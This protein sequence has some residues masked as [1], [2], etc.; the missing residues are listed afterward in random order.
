[1]ETITLTFGTKGCVN[2]SVSKVQNNYEEHNLLPIVIEESGPE[3]YAVNIF[4]ADDL[5]SVFPVFKASETSY[6][7]FEHN[8]KIS[9]FIKVEKNGKISSFPINSTVYGLEILNKQKQNLFEKSGGHTL[10]NLVIWF[11]VDEGVDECGILLKNNDQSDRNH[12]RDN[13]YARDNDH[14]DDDDYARN[15]RDHGDDDDIDSLDSLSSRKCKKVISKEKPIVRNSTIRTKEKAT[16]ALNNTSN[17][18]YISAPFK[19]P[20]QM[21]KRIFN[22]YFKTSNK[23]MGNLYL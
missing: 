23:M 3:T 21:N 1:M 5:T 14:G 17:E 7:K 16:V 13:D 9:P 12:N 8:D 18:K 11:G 6:F 19:V 22:F 4:G 20:S 2:F 15:R 10:K